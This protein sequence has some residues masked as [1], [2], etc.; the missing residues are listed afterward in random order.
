[1][2]KIELTKSERDNLLT[3]LTGD[4]R[5]QLTGNEAFEFTKIVGKIASAKEDVEK[6]AT[7][8]IEE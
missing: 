2:I 5:V 1:M 8:I 6:N 3:F 4:G 7:P